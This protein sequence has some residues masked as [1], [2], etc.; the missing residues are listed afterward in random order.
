MLSV[1]KQSINF[2]SFS[3]QLF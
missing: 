3:F 1:E 2:R